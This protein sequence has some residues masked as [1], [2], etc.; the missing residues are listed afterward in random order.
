MEQALSIWRQVGDRWAI[1]NTLTGLGDVAGEEKDYPTSRAYYSESLGINR[2]LDDRLALAYI[3]EALGCLAA[4]Q[5]D[6]ERAMLA[7]RRG[8]G[9]ACGHRCAVATD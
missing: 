8:I 7:C 9:V 1:A 4:A 2:E 3:F 6:P 5:S